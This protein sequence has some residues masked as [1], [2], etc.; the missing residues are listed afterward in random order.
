[1]LDGV[2][3]EQFDGRLLILIRSP[4]REK[5][6]YG[7]RVTHFPADR[8]NGKQRRSGGLRKAPDLSAEVFNPRRWLVQPLFDHH[9]EGENQHGDCEARSRH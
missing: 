8:D 5:K 2:D 1:M 4:F 7:R 9:P 6:H 3:S